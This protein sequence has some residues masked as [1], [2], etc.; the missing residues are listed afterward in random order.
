MK[1]PGNTGKPRKDKGKSQGKGRKAS[2]PGIVQSWEAF[3]ESAMREY[4]DA[5]ADDLAAQLDELEQAL[6]SSN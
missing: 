2:Q 4:L 3:S 1:L 6:R 5:V